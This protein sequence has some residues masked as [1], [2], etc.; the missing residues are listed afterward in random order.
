MT[1]L[2]GPERLM[3]RMR[4]CRLQRAQ[5]VHPTPP[6]ARVKA[7]A[8]QPGPGTPAPRATTG[9][10]GNAAATVCG[11]GVGLDCRRCGMWPGSCTLPR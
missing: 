5:M 10:L 1:G 9:N 2:A 6:L 11:G 3:R 7:Q 8:T 4:I